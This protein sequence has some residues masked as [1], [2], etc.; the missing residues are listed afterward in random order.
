MKTKI[1]C[2]PY[3]GASKNIYY[4]WMK[5]Y[6]NKKFEFVPIEYKGHGS[7]YNEGFYNNLDDVLQDLMNSIFA[8]IKNETCEY[9]ILGHSLG[10]LLAFHL[11]LKIENSN[12]QFPKCIIVSSS[13]P[14]RK[15]KQ[16][17]VNKNTI[18]EKVYKMGHI[19]ESVYNNKEVYKIYSEIIYRDV[20]LDY[21]CHTL[22]NLEKIKVPII[23]FYGKNDNSINIH[24][25]NKWNKYTTNKCFIEE[26][27]GDHFFVFE[28]IFNIIHCIE[29]ALKY[30]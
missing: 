12:K 14:P 16:I 29:K 19:P 8:N 9:I 22:Y 27:N 1:F 7:R 24:E 4:D 25:V 21:D 15:L 3:A 26:Y 17:D 30:I 23:G 10:S 5:I 13:E 28:E 2:L 6:S 11:C 20:L 18:I